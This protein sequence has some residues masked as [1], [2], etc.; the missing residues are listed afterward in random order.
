MTRLHTKTPIVSQ[1]SGLLYVRNV[2]WPGKDIP[3]GCPKAG[4]PERRL[5]LLVCDGASVLLLKFSFH[6]W[7][8]LHCKTT[9]SP[10][11]VGQQG[12]VAEKLGP[13]IYDAVAIPVPH[14]QAVALAHPAGQFRKAVSVIVKVGSGFKPGGI[15]NSVAIQ[16]QD[17][18][19]NPDCFGGSKLVFDGVDWQI[20]TIFQLTK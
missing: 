8:R 2:F 4:G 10:H 20:T 13:I 9:G 7:F 15:Y 14:Q 19:V 12:I 3:A 16:I 18:R 11:P 17:Q 6:P 1:A 5:A